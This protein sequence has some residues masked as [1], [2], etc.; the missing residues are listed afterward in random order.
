M[1][2]LKI[3]AV[4]HAVIELLI[5]CLIPFMYP[6]SGWLG[7]S[8]PTSFPDLFPGN[9]PKTAI[10]R[11]VKLV[12]MN[13][14]RSVEFR[15]TRR[16]VRL[17]DMAF[18]QIWRRMKS[19]RSVIWFPHTSEA[20]EYLDLLNEVDPESLVA[21][22]AVQQILE[23]FQGHGNK[24]SWKVRVKAR[25]L[26][27]K[28]FQSAEFDLITYS[29][30]MC[31]SEQQLIVERRHYYIDFSTQEIRSTGYSKVKCRSQS[32]IDHEE[33]LRATFPSL[34]DLEKDEVGSLAIEAVCLDRGRV[35]P[36]E[37]LDR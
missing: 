35:Q 19:L 17:P 3:G 28:Q 36:N 6:T 14:D 18:V 5:H 33:Y 37:D 11:N 2:N 30:G 20:Q 1:K 32:A 10:I 9:V 13:K 26:T 25:S 27:L 12:F 8:K 21:A 16:S 34:D 22:S 7:K 15:D 4:I 23:N 31:G 24:V 29:I